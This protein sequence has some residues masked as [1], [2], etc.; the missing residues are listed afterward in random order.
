MLTDLM[1]GRPLTP[2]T[3]NDFENVKR[4][5]WMK[6]DGITQCPRMSSLFRHEKDGK[7]TY[8]DNNRVVMIDQDGG[9]WHNGLVSR[10]VNEKYPIKLPYRGGEKYKVYCEEYTIDENGNKV[11][12]LGEY[13]RLRIIKIVKPDGTVEEIDKTYEV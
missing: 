4:E 8:T 10:L 3:E 5:P 2:I 6:D 11:D 1:D 7:V 13:N 12:I 9:T